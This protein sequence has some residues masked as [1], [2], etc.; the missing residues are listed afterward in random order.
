[1]RPMY[2]EKTNDESVTALSVSILQANWFIRLLN[3]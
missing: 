2:I 3:A 1:M